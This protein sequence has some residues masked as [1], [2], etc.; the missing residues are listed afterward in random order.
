MSDHQP[1][2]PNQ[3]QTPAPSSAGAPVN[4]TAA[5]WKRL[6][7]GIIDLFLVSFFVTP[8]IYRFHLD[9]IADNPFNV[10]PDIA[11]KVLLCEVMVFFVLNFVLLMRRGQ[12]LGKWLFSLAIVD[13]NN[14]KPNIINLVLNRYMIQLAMVIVPFLNP[15]DVLLMLF[16][17]DRR[18]IHDLLAKTKVIDLKIVVV[19]APNSFIA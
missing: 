16:R 5:L 12:T 9:K 1:E 17:R 18:C 7:A 4:N 13:L 8:F 10:P 3:Q 6:A 2:Q 19:A 14:Q 11:L 15:I